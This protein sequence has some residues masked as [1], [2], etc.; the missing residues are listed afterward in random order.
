MGLQREGLRRAYVAS[1]AQQYHRRIS[2]RE[3]DCFLSG[4]VDVRSRAQDLLKEHKAPIFAPKAG[5][6]WQCQHRP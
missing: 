5:L 3:H 4:S 6:V 1:S 2:Y